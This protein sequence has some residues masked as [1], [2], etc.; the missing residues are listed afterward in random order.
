M[1]CCVFDI[2]VGLFEVVLN[3]FGCDVG[4]LFVFLVELMVGLMSGGVYGW[5]D[6][7]GVFDCLLVG[8]GFV[9]LC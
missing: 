9:V 8:M 5:F 6:V 2:L 4:I 7:D 3:W 1:L